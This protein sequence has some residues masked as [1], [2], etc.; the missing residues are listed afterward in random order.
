MWLRRPPRWWQDGSAEDDHEAGTQVKRI[1][2]SDWRSVEESDGAEEAVTASQARA[3][4]ED[5]GAMSR[6][7]TGIKRKFNHASGSWSTWSLRGGATSIHK[8]CREASLGMGGTQRFCE[9]LDD[10]GSLFVKDHTIHTLSSGSSA[11][12][13]W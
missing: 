13:G 6:S 9:E 11:G 10:M 1:R 7:N 5:P 12:P 4:N 3:S 2:P 8:G